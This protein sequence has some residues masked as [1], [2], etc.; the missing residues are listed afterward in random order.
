MQSSIS[1]PG[2]ERL[3]SSQ[4][5]YLDTTGS[6]ADVPGDV[7]NFPL[8]LRISDAAIIDAVQ[9]GAADIRFVDSDGTTRLPYEI[10]RWDQVN[11]QALVWV[12]VPLVKGNSNQN[13]ITL[14]YDDAVDGSVVDGQ[15][16]AS[17]WNDY[18][19][20]WHFAESGLARDSSPFG[21][22]G[23]DEGGVDRKLSF[24]GASAPGKSL[25]E[26]RSR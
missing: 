2:V 3:L 22:D 16:P 24:N 7:V 25:C 11:N 1:Q 18:A 9:P 17:L 8:L 19:G 15:D 14:L 6:G 20:V 4:R 26:R 23:I 12:L 5:F 21:N 10:E 13:F